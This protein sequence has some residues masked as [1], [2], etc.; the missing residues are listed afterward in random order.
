M[1][2]TQYHPTLSYSTAVLRPSSIHSLWHRWFINAWVQTLIM[3]PTVELMMIF[4]LPIHI[5]SN[6]WTKGNLRPIDISDA[7]S[8]RVH[9]NS[10]TTTTK[11][12][13]VHSNSHTRGVTPQISNMKWGQFDFAAKLF[14]T[15]I[16]S[17][18]I[19][20]ENMDKML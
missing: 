10:P 4:F 19:V 7:Q 6:S 1:P 14:T 11:S 3:E 12:I 13:W 20:K 5:Y 15:L 9:S 17:N 8:F 18:V 2:G 16:K